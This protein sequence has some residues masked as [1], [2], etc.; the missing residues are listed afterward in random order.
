MSDLPPVISILTAFFPW[1]FI[2]LGILVL[3]AMYIV[4][5]AVIVRQETL[6]SRV[7]EIPF[8]PVLRIVALGHFLVSL[9]AF[10]LALL[11]L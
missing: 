1:G 4:F 9:V 6:M 8:S 10:F 3:I 5:A 2:Q 7:V 11:I